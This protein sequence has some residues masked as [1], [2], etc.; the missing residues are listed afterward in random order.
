[1]NATFA[2]TQK[3]RWTNGINILYYQ[4]NE[5][6]RYGL[7]WQSS[8]P[9]AKW[10]RFELSIQHNTMPNTATTNPQN[11]ENTTNQWRGRAGISFNF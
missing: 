5:S 2:L 3:L 4:Q 1:M 8:I 10:A 11:T 6:S 7:G 9:L